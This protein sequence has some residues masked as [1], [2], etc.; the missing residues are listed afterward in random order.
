MKVKPAGESLS[1][2]RREAQINLERCL[3][4]L[5]RHGESGL[6]AELDRMYPGTKASPPPDES[7]FERVPLG[8]LGPDSFALILKTPV[9]L[10]KKVV[11]PSLPEIPKD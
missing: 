6:Q 5:D 4:A 1:R 10:Q 9:M 8:N 3:E 11:K 7:L 2:P